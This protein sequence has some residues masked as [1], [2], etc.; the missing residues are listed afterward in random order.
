VLNDNY[1]FYF[2]TLGTRFDGEVVNHA[3][4]RH[5]QLLEYFRQ[6]WERS[7]TSEDLRQL[8]I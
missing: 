4:G 8:A 5:A 2:R 7:E 3:P 1:G 6:V